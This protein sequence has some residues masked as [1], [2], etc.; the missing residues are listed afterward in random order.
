MKIILSRKGFDSEFGKKP[1]PIFPDGRMVSL[2]IP[3]DHSRIKYKDIR[4]SSHNFGSLISDLTGGGV[5]P[6]DGAHLDP[7]IRADSIPRHPAWRPIFGQLGSAQGHLENHGV[8]AGDLFLFFGLFREVVAD[9]G[10]ITYRKGSPTRHIIWGWLQVDEVLNVDSC[11]RS[12][13]TWAT[14]HPHFDRSPDTSNTMYIGSKDLNL[15]GMKESRV[16]GGGAFQSFAEKL[17]L[18]ATS[19]T[20][21]SLWELPGWFYPGNGRTPMTYHGN[22]DRWEQTQTGTRLQTVGKGQEFILDC[23]EYPEA[24]GWVHG[25]LASS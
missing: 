22:L 12:R 8:Q 4:F 6:A 9:C 3:D 24:L 23:D 15:P 17:Q 18:T 10:K 1:S 20:T 19:V 13:Y 5:S 25:L 16:S 11:D 21:C 14:Y 7:D 2:P